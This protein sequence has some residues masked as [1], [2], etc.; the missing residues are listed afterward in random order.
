MFKLDSESQVFSLEFT[1]FENLYLATEDRSLFKAQIL[2]Q[3]AVQ[4]KTVIITESP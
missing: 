1:M 3:N 4:H 2:V